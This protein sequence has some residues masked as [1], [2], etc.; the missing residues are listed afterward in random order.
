[1]RKEA[2]EKKMECFIYRCNKKDGLYLYLADRDN[3]SELPEALKQL[4]GRLNFVMSLTLTPTR[5][6][7]S[8]NVEEVMDNLMHQGYHLQLPP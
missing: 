4:T 5:T 2:N 8:V 6:L 3:F 7:A 1:M